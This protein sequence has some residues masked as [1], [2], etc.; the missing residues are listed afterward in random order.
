MSGEGM[1]AP[2][3]RL[4]R[5]PL[6]APLSRK[7][8][9]GTKWFFVPS[10]GTARSSVRMALIV[11]MTW[12][13]GTNLLVGG[14]V[15][16]ERIYYTTRRPEGWQLHLL[17]AGSAPKQIT[18]DPALSYDAAFSPDAHWL[19]FCSERS[20]SP[21]LYAM[22]LARRGSTRQLTAG[23]YQHAAPA[24][25]PD[26]KDLL[27]VGDRDGSA[28]VFRMAFRPDGSL[29]G[30][31]AVNLTRDPASDFRPAVSPDGMR[32]AFSS[33]RDVGRVYPFKAEIYVMNRDGSGV[34]RVTSLEGMSGSPVWS[35]DGRRI[36][37]YSDHD[38][39][40][41]RIWAVDADGHN[42]HAL[43]PK[44]LT[45]LS[46]AVLPNGRI[47][48]AARRGDG[49]EIRS[50]AEDGSGL[51]SESGL[52]DC[53]APAVER[54]TGR[55]VC[56]GPGRPGGPPPFLSPSAHVE[57][58]LPDRT[59]EV[60][61]IHGFFCGFGP[62]GREVATGRW[63]GS[64]EEADMHLVASR[65]DGSAERELFRPPKRAAIWGISW[66]TRADLLAFTVGP[67][68]AADDAVVD[69]W[70]VRGDGTG[71]RNL[72][73]GKY[74][75]NAF[76]DIT[77]DGREIVFRSTRDGN[78]D[79]YLMRSDGTDVQRIVSGP[80][81]HTMPSISPSA[82]LVVFSTFQLWL[83]RLK[84]RRPEGAALLYQEFFPSVHPRFS[85]DG[86]WIAFVSRRAWLNDEGPLSN[87]NSQPYGEIF[88]APVS[89]GGEP[90]RLTH[91]RWED[92]VPCWG[93]TSRR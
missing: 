59:L 2:N 83:Q 18:N 44:D 5:T 39:G 65:P 86:K 6:R 19:V 49:F 70:T 63:L 56:V 48:F 52:Q 27:F 11:G 87:G 81:T 50:L 90:I 88:V 12:F 67:T 41:F 76:P 23:P 46:P 45:A 31:D 54:S 71:A 32:I 75:N 3:P 4:Q 68:F 43:T 64:E 8:L 82:D 14:D 93:S 16:R 30:D 60:R 24:F 47:A 34:R 85:P 37:F 22:D 77:P 74:R 36:Y 10:W 91:D 35:S 20:G 15:P 92:S 58:R 79:L 42:P 21:Q 13:G 89:G 51:R 9:G 33:D 17:E 55:I 38:G 57:V 78:R 25:T 28:D 72:T 53:R 80:G 7:P 84:G 69:I 26:G 1:F 61:G 29:T 73:A 62:D 66:A 40:T